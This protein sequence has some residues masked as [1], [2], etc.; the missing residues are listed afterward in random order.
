MRKILK[1]PVNPV[2]FHYFSS[3]AHCGA[4]NASDAQDA[5]RRNIPLRGRWRFKTDS[6]F[7][8]DLITSGAV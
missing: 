2:Y 5:P 6:D 1:N 4:D 7:V 3:V 8:S